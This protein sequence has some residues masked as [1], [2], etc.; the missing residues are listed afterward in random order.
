MQHTIC[1]MPEYGHAVAALHLLRCIFSH[2]LF[3][4][5]AIVMDMVLTCIKIRNEQITNCDLG[6]M[7]E[8]RFA[9]CLPALNIR[10]MRLVLV[11]RAA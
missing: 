11:S 10:A 4:L 8:G 3:T 2:L 1:S 9:D 5:S 6:L 7:K